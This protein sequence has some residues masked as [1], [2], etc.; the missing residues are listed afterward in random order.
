MAVL[1]IWYRTSK[2]DSAVFFGEKG[3]ALAEKINFLKDMVR[4]TAEYGRVMRDLGNVPKSLEMQLKAL[5]I[6]KENNL[7]EET[8][9][10]LNYLGGNY[11]ELKLL[12]MR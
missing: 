3:M 5:R 11:A 8:G 2:P 6:A 4:N 1:S 7:L 12:F 10:P 9:R